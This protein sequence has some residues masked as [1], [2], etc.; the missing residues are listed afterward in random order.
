MEKTEYIEILIVEDNASD[1]ELLLNVLEK[2]NLDNN[3]WVV[4]DG[5]E[6]LRRIKADPKTR[7]IP[8]VMVTSSTQETDIVES[9]KLG[10]NS[11]IVKP[12]DFTQYSKSIHE[13][14]MYWLRL[15]TPML[16]I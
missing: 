5:M 7:H 9:Y 16:T 1:E 4:R 2:Y 15:N 12:V 14:A 13:I 10:A 6:A 8:V 3:A 11:Y